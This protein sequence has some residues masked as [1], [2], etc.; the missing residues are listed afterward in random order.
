MMGLGSG[1]LA[2]PASA[3]VARTDDE[4]PPATAA[5]DP[6][7]ANT[8]TSPAPTMP[9][10]D[11]AKKS[12]KT[13]WY[14]MLEWT[15]F[16]DGYYA[17]NYLFPKRP[18]TSNNG[19]GIRAFD[20]NTG[21]SFAWFALD[22]TYP[23]GGALGLV[24]M[25]VNLRV[26]PSSPQLALAQDTAIG[27]AFIKQ[28]YLTIQATKSLTIDFG[29]FD[30][31]YGAEVADSFANHTYTRGALYNQ[32]Q[33]FHHT[34]LRVTW[35]ATD[36]FA[37]KF[38]AV[39][40]WNNALDNNTMKSFGIQFAYSGKMFGASLGYLV[41]PEQPDNNEDFRHFI[42]FVG[43]LS[44][45][46]LAL[47]LNF[48]FVLD[49]V[50]G[51]TQKALGVM[52]S[53]TYAF[54]KMWALGFRGEFLSDMDGTAGNSLG[55]L[56]VNNETQNLITGTITIDMNL[57]SYCLIRL[58]TRLDYATQGGF[59]KGRSET[60]KWQLTNTLGLVVKTN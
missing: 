25:T 6:P 15:M 41:G 57:S 14:D 38:I 45:G 39:N 7:P 13:A 3:P 51:E 9:P 49:N 1:A 40:G 52:L 24:G 36:A 46:N 55:A 59:Q 58:D 2:Q 27:I 8:M 4:P 60:E 29:K 19:L 44:L 30:T 50:G 12:K 28:A 31:L 48:D 20:P 16:V 23:T 53:G 18:E 22:V 33:P 54:N 32:L 26:G 5:K 47:A 11:T 21:F 37:V 34:G 35:A 42:D 56:K 17:V 10:A 43:T